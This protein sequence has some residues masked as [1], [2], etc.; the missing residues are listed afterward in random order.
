M[1]KLFMRVVI[2]GRTF[3]YHSMKANFK[4]KLNFNLNG[5]FLNLIPRTDQ[6]RVKVFFITLNVWIK[7]FVKPFSNCRQVNLSMIQLA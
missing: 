7:P 6:S 5:L 1:R 3:I 4:F 2:I